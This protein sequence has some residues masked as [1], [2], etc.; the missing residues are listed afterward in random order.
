M[1]VID[2]VGG[3][4]VAVSAS[5]VVAVGDETRVESK[6]VPGSL[7]MSCCVPNRD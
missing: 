4:A 6:S 3:S 7:S 2:S 5:D 1:L